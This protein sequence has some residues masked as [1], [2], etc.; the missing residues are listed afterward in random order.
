[1][2]AKC[3]DPIYVEPPKTAGDPDPDSVTM[4]HL[5]TM[6]YGESKGHVFDDVT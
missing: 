4:E 3:R 2:K 1:M 6:A 5:L